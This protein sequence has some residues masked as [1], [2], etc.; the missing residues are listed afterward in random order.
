MTRVF[1]NPWFAKFARK[2]RIADHV[3]HEAVLRA[4]Q[5]LIDADL[6]GGVIK[7]RL[8]RQGQGRSGGYRSLVL[9]KSGSRA[10]FVSGFAKS[11]RSNISAADEQGLKS[12]A[13]IML[14]LTEANM[15][16]LVRKNEIV[17]V[18]YNAES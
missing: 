7:Q 16:E 11:A 13:D 12:A 3:L 18:T 10:I 8:A 2:E 6:G 14:A 17:E 15:D 1:K 4:E 9:F 5:G